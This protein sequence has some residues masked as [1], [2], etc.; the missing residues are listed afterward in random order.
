M[1]DN[2][3][4]EESLEKFVGCVENYYRILKAVAIEPI[5]FRVLGMI[6]LAISENPYMSE[7]V[8]SRTKIYVLIIEVLD[9]YMPAI[10]NNPL[11]H[12]YYALALYEL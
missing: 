9:H 6:R 10:G 7:E 3:M 1:L 4:V 2:E 5:L 8:N 11:V 12:Y